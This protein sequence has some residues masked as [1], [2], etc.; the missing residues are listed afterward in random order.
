MYKLLNELTGKSSYQS[1]TPSLIS[2]SNNGNNIPTDLDVAE[3]LNVFF[4]NIG[5]TLK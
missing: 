4:A 5:K 2:C 3:K 1:I